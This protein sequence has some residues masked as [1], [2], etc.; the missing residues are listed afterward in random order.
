MN[1]PLNTVL[2]GNCLGVLEKLPEAS[3]DMVFADPP[4]NLQLNDTLYRPDNS[5][6]DSV[7]EGWD[8]F[9]DYA[10][11]DD[12]LRRWLQAV[13]RVLKPNGCLWV[14][15]TYHNIFRVGTCLQDLGFWILNDVIWQ[16]ANP[17]PNFRGTR[18][19]NAHETLIWCT[20][21][22]KARYTFHYDRM[23]SFNDDV[24]MR[25]DWFIPLCGGAE[26]LRNDDGQ[27]LHP[28]QKPEA[29]LQR[30]LLMTT[31]PGDVVLDPFFG[32][33]TT[34]AVAKKLGRHYIG[35]EVDPTYI[36]A[37]EE[38]L[39]SIEPISELYLDF[40]K[41]KQDN[42]KIPFGVIVEAGLLEPGDYLYDE[43]GHQEAVVGADGTITWQNSRG[44]IHKI[45]AKALQTDRCNGW[46]YWH[47]RQDGELKPID[48]LRDKLKQTWTEAA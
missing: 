15:G 9:A 22:P 2:Q 36:A 34:G 4:Y 3:V 18:L 38:R 32:S 44:S 27:R 16:K 31:N 8:Q 30:V 28:T 39:A 7:D 25:S 21:S 40:P 33:G 37:A 5:R 43:D 10:A 26:R 13:R 46:L 29:L 48:M 11:Y 47:Y 17:M 42:V 45:G 24:Q 1:L 6:V 19:T 20:P 35:I 14:I 23:K 41:S 12:F